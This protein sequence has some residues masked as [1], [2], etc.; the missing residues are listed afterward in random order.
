VCHSLDI[1]RCDL[2]T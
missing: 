2:I 1:K